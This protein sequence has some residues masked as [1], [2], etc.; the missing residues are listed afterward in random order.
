[1]YSPQFGMSRHRLSSALTAKFAFSGNGAIA[2]IRMKLY[3]S[4]EFWHKSNNL[5]KVCHRC[6]KNNDNIQLQFCTMQPFPYAGGRAKTGSQGLIVRCGPTGPTVGRSASRPANKPETQRHGQSTPKATLLA[7]EPA[8][9]AQRDA[10]AELVALASKQNLNRRQKVKRGAFRSLIPSRIIVR[11]S[12]KRI[13]HLPQAFQ[14]RRATESHKGA[15]PGLKRCGAGLRLQL[16]LR[17]SIWRRKRICIF[18]RVPALRTATLT[19]KSC[20]S[21]SPIAK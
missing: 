18:D 1:M 12:Q 10:Y 14:T 2:G 16:G 15:C 4:S 11:G 5:P 9:E 6:T 20:I 7:Q 3:R 17:T 19:V 13:A 21:R 8:V